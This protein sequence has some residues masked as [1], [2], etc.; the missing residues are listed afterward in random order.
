MIFKVKEKIQIKGISETAPFKKLINK[1]S[2]IFIL[3][4]VIFKKKNVLWT[5]S[6]VVNLSSLYEYVSFN[7]KPHT[8]NYLNNKIKY[9]VGGA[10]W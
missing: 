6:I 10:K 8:E 4:I 7:S 2:I 1:N 3:A 9:G 5:F